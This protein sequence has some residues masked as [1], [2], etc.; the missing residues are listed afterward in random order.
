MTTWARW[1]D[2]N[3][4]TKK[5]LVLFRGYSTSHF[6]E[7]VE[8]NYEAPCGNTHAYSGHLAVM[9]L[10]WKIGIHLN[11][12][13]CG[14]IWNSGGTCDNE[15]EPIYDEQY[16]QMKDYI[17]MLEMVEGLLKGMKMPDWVEVPLP[18]TSRDSKVLASSYA[19]GCGSIL[20]G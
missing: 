16:L 17:P 6:R 11:T 4:D 10:T 14:G 15:T 19:K 8:A 1:I 20:L 13:T 18:L 5:T 3:V 2:A 7:L 12:A 9:M